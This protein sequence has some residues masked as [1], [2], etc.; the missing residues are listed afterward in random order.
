MPG[1]RLVITVHGIRTFGGWQERLEALL[2]EE[3]ARRGQSIRVVNY[4]YG[5]FSALAFASVLLRWLTVRR[6]RR[7]LCTLAAEGWDRIDIVAHSF[8]TFVAAKALESMRNEGCPRIGTLILAGSVLP[9]RF[10]WSELVPRCVGRVVN[11]CG[12]R[13]GI[14]LLSQALPL[15]GMAGRSGF[16]GMTSAILR[17]RFFDFGHSG[18]FIEGG[19]PTDFMSRHWVP[20][21]FGDTAATPA[22]DERPG[23]W[24]AGIQA[25]LLNNAAPLKLLSYAALAGAIWFWGGSYAARQ[26]AMRAV[27]R[28]M[29]YIA[30][31]GGKEKLWFNE[32]ADPSESIHRLAALGP[33]HEIDLAA[34][35]VTDDDLLALPPSPTL[36][37]LKL[38]K[39]AVTARSLSALDRFPQLRELSIFDAPLRELPGRLPPLRRLRT[40]DLENTGI[41]DADVAALAPMAALEELDLTNNE[42]RGPGLAHLQ[43]CTALRKLKMSSNLI[44][45]DGLAAVGRLTRL[46]ALDLESNPLQGRELARLAPLRELES[47]N[48][49]F[50]SIDDEGLSHLPAFPRLK[51]LL[52]T[53]DVK[54]TGSTFAAIGALRS[55]EELW[56]KDTRVNA[57][58]LEHL[59]GLP[60]LRIL[61][62]PATKVGPGALARVKE[63]KGLKELYLGANN[64]ANADIQELADMPSLQVLYVP[65]NPDIT[66]AALE[67]IARL[68]RLREL[69]IEQTS[70]TA[71]GRARLQKARP[72]L[73]I[74]F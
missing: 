27:T 8:G 65:L 11:E 24:R 35:K 13:D 28:E 25:F 9:A 45:D 22:V 17:N 39:T 5:Y 43:S 49:S 67:A 47:L 2:S 31:D 53:S 4:K 57:A 58:A 56:V 12:H 20:L 38:G 30:T 19:K 72:S 66:D 18:Y 3:A 61:A 41:D 40:L 33:L 71:T 29:G 46:R 7:E 15:L 21:L 70:T 42:I 16:Q 36:A 74:L 1:S 60:N 23:H 69:S 64:L 6:F 48:L 54:V 68:P 59:V 32:K 10:R 26:F 63:M 52:M 55:L 34:T 44:N 50:T 62:L 14:L 73:K 51:E 37:V